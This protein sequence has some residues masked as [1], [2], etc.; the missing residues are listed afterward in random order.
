MVLGRG[1]VV[2]VLAVKI[3]RESRDRESRGIAA[4]IFDVAT[5]TV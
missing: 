2:I 4:L 1:K 3:D 5:R